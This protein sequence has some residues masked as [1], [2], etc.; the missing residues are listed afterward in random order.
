MV[1]GGP[2]A[3]N[4]VMPHCSHATGRSTGGLTEDHELDGEPDGGAA[5]R[6]LVAAVNTGVVESHVAHGQPTVSS[7]PVTGDV[8]PG[9]E[10]PAKM[11]A[12]VDDHWLDAER[13]VVKPAERRRSVG[14]RSSGTAERHV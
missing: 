3:L 6:Q 11:Q 9:G 13:P 8:M 4:P 7:R 12:G 1:V 10:L 2:G 14:A 5:G